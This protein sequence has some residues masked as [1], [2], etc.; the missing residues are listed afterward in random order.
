MLFTHEDMS[1]LFISHSF[2]DDAFVRELRAA[3][4]D[5]GHNGW[6]DSREVIGGDL[7]WSKI[8]KAIEEASAFIVVVSPAVLQS[9]WVGKEVRHA[10][11][12]LEQRGKDEFPV[13][14][15]SLDGTKLGVLEQFFTEEPVYINVSSKAGGIE[16]A[17]DP[18]LSALRQRPD[19][20]ESKFST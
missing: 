7:L 5:H 12:V 11:T 14:P 8:Q 2:Q 19:L 1:Q 13:I 6:A 9:A 16:A 3:L 18:L 20:V 10:L 15:L 17:I 4:A